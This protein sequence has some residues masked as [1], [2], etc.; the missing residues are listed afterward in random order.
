MGGAE[1]KVTLQSRVLILKM[2]A[3]M[4]WGH[5]ILHSL[6]PVFVHVSYTEWG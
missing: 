3:S 5:E 1:D 6:V 4:R 2:L